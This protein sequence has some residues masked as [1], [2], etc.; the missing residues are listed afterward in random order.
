MGWFWPRSPIKRCF[1]KK[2]W[3]LKIPQLCLTLC[4][5]MDYTVLG[6]FQARILEWVAFPFSRGSS[7]SGDRTQ[8]SCIAGRFL[9]SWA[10]SVSWGIRQKKSTWLYL[11]STLH[12][13]WFRQISIKQIKSV[14]PKR[15]QPWIFIGRTDAEADASV[16]WP[17]NVKNWLSG[18]YTD[19]VKDWGQEEKGMAEDEMAGW[20]HQLNGHEFGWTLGVRNGQGGLACRSPW[21][22]KELDTTERLN[23]RVHLVKAM[24]SPLVMYRCEIWIIKKPEGQR[25]DAF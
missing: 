12:T 5:P 3:K 19:A 21:G 14:N 16:L 7:Q 15:N 17:P 11:D 25:I 24:V 20:H 22:R 2:V 18:K 9:T 8:V 4:N 10:A 23:W 1:M 6:I 13:R